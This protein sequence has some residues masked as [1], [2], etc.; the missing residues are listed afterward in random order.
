MNAFS[1]IPDGGGIHARW[2]EPFGKRAEER[3]F[4]SKSDWYATRLNGIRLAASIDSKGCLT[5]FK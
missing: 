2:M 3:I 5:Y 1:P 4:S